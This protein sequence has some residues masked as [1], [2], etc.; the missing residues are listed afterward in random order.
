MLYLMN[1]AGDSKDGIVP[2]SMNL[3]ILIEKTTDFKVRED[4]T[5]RTILHFMAFYGVECDLD[6][7]VANSDL[8]AV[9]LQTRQL[10]IDNVRSVEV[11]SP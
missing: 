10:P 7:V 2:A 1:T 5:D 3:R 6:R 4:G 11:R 9:T 8:E